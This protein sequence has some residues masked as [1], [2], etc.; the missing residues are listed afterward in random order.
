MNDKEIRAIARAFDNWIKT[1]L[2]Q[3]YLLENEKAML[4]Y[5]KNKEAGLS[6]SKLAFLAG[7]TI[8]KQEVK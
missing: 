7:Y 3:N 2:K 4:K 1:A 5:C 6:F 8:G